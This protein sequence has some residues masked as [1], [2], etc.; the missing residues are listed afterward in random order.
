LPWFTSISSKI[1]CYTL[2]LAGK[3]K[4][5]FSA[6]AEKA[7]ENPSDIAE[8]H[9]VWRKRKIADRMMDYPSTK[10]SRVSLSKHGSSP[11]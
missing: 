1:V 11:A 2:D 5:V 7:D 4:V 9:R 3:V 10:L 6:I 8:F